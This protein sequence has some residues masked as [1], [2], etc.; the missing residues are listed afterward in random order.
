M[1]EVGAALLGLGFGAS[2]FASLCL[3]VG[4]FRGGS[5]QRWGWVLSLIAVAALAGAAVLLAVCF[6]GGDTS[7]RYVVFYRSDS[8]SAFAWLYRLSGLWSGREGSLLLWACF[9]AA[10]VALVAAFALRRLERSGSGGSDC[11]VRDTCRLDALASAGLM[12]LVA[13]FAAVLVFSPDNQ[14]FAALPAEY[15]DTDGSL[16]GEA[17]AWGLSSLLEHWA[18]VIHPPL[19]FLGYAGLL[20]PFAYAAAGTLLRIDRAVW[21]ARCRL[22]ALAGWLFLSCGMAVGALWAYTVLG[23]G[24][25]WGW[26]AVENATLLPWLAAVALLHSL[27][28]S[29]QKPL[30]PNGVLLLSAA[31]AALVMLASFI[32]RS[33]IIGSVHAF[34]GDPSSQVLF[35]LLT[36]APVAVALV[37]AMACRPPSVSQA[38]QVRGEDEPEPAEGLVSREAAFLLG[39]ILLLGFAA[40]VGYMTLAPALPAPLPGAGQAFSATAFQ[41]VAAPLGILYLLLAALCPLLGWHRT[42]G[43][44]FWRRLRAPL[45]VAAVLF[46]LMAWYFAAVLL[47]A[48]NDILDAGGTARDT[49]LE[50]GPAWY[51]NGLALLGFFAASLLLC[52]AL[53]SLA[54][55]WKRGRRAGALG[56]FVSHAGMAVVLVGLIGSTMYVTSASALLPYDAETNTAERALVIGDYR[57][58]YRDKEVVIAENQTDLF[59]T[60]FLTVSENDEPVAEVAP[61]LQMVS[62]T[63]QHQLHAD[64]LHKPLEDLFVVYRGVD[65][66]GDEPSLILEASVHPLITFVWAGFALVVAGGALSLGSALRQ[67]RRP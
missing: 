34:T 53:A 64:I 30:F 32:T 36:V 47:P 10:G 59:N 2:L 56:G 55:S 33:G 25:F 29:R 38:L 9:Q 12:G 20:V 3:A 11:G 28:A 46:V 43:R 35:A 6:V 52:T 15:L 5:R 44:A 63:Q 54:R 16:Q 42:E 1:A 23:W 49:L 14:L 40:V 57:L 58:D 65:S 67:R 50:Q 31:V 8:T 22:G 37:L 26:D 7:I 18:M 62:T 13:V 60:L 61:M 27:R 45:V 24:G 39:N 48:Y 41:I 17:T 21:M 4:A 19:L 51:Y 66:H